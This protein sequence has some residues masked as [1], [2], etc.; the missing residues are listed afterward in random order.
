ML[1]ISYD[2]YRIEALLIYLLYTIRQFMLNF[3]VRIGKS[4]AF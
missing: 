4:Y 2:F 1:P 3:L